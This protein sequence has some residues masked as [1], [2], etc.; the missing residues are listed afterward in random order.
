MK[1]ENQFTDIAEYCNRKRGHS[2][3]VRS[4]ID[5]DAAEVVRALAKLAAPH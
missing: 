3:E 4:E 2:M 5:G 1:A